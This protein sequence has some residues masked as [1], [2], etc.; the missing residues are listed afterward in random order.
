MLEEQLHNFYTANPK[1]EERVK[2]LLDSRSSEQSVPIGSAV[3][4]GHRNS[5]SQSVVH[6][7]RDGKSG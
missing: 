1:E 4:L 3:R 6:C 5:V 7:G 2:E